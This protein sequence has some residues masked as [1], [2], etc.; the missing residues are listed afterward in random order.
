MVRSTKPRSRSC[1]FFK[2]SQAFRATFAPEKFVYLEDRPKA[3]RLRMLLAASGVGDKSWRQWPTKGRGS[4]KQHEALIWDPV[5]CYHRQEA[6]EVN[7]PLRGL[8]S[9]YE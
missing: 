6:P 4:N 3:K 8:Q 7:Q 1:K 2:R 9:S 5:T